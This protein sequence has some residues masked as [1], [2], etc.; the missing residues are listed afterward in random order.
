MK[1][2]LLVL[3]AVMG[4]TFAAN[5]QNNDKAIGLRLG[6]G[7]EISYQTPMGSNRLELDLGSLDA[8]LYHYN[9]NF[10]S[11]TGTY[12][13][14][15]GLPVDGLGWY[16][17]PGVMAGFYLSDYGDDYNGLNIGIGGIIGLDYKFNGIPLQMSLDARPMYSVVHPKYFNGIGYSAALGVRYT[18]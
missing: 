13:W 8:L 11:L 3:I 12:Q 14:V 9:W 16:V 7:N 17:G 10:L 5:A 1:K 6:Y 4:L 15:F 2:L 18:F